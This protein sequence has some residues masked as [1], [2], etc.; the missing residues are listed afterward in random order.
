VVVGRNL[1]LKARDRDPARSHRVCAELGATDEGTLAQLDTYFGV[2]RGRLKLREQPPG[3]AQLI[4]YARAEDRGSKESRYRIVAVPEASEMKAA[5]AAALGIRVEVRKARRL[6]LW[7][8]VRIHLDEVEELGSFIEFEG[9][10]TA[11]TEADGF[12]PLLTDL[13]RRFLIEDDDLL[14]VSYSDLVEAAAGLMTIPRPC[15]EVG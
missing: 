2:P 6:F 8:G 12:A 9:V 3:S 4:A 7:E 14:A 10:A 13:R 5:L 1:E 11:D 15:H